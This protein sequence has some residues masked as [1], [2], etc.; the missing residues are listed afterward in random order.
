[1]SGRVNGDLF[2]FDE[3]VLRSSDERAIVVTAPSELL[4]ACDALSIDR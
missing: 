3:H 4:I 1:M 2:L